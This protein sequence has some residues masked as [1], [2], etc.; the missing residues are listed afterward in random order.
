MVEQSTNRKQIKTQGS[1][2][3]EIRNIFAA[4]WE[5]KIRESKLFDKEDDSSSWEVTEKNYL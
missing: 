4:D 5:N 2:S 1:T 3:M